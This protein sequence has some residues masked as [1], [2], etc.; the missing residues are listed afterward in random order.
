MKIGID[1]RLIGK[2]RTGDEAVFFNLVKNLAEID[3]QNEYVLLTDITDEKMLENIGEKLGIKGKGNFRITAL[4]SKNKFEWNFFA[5]PAYLRKNPVDIYHTQYITPWFVPKKTKITT[6]IHDI[7]FNFYPQ[8]IR[9]F[10]LFFL[11]TLIPLSIARAD[12]VIGVSE[13][14]CS[15]IESYYKTSESKLAHVPNAVGD[16][17]LAEEAGKERLAEVRSK[18]GLPDKFILYLGTLQPRKNVPRL[19][20]AYARIKN[21]LQGTKLVIAGS[22]SAHNFDRRIDEAIAVHGLEGEVVFPGYVAD[23]DKKALY[24]SAEAF[25]FPSLYEGFGIPVL[26]AFSAGAPV[27]ANGIPS[28]KEVG[29]EGAMFFDAANL[30]EFADKLY[31]VSVD[32]PTQER[33]KKAGIERVG[34]FSWEKSARK[35]LAVWQELWDNAK[36]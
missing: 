8:F 26:E 33:L 23:E 36:N 21:K 10:D 9:P 4:E 18:Y 35:T 24:A 7:S 1:I 6:I 25:V 22:R 20:E 13:F 3:G 34:F 5:L 32:G 14:T 30:D 11:K 17:F 31:T 28:L 27:L 12:K 19:I 15:E 2:N 29:G 16:A